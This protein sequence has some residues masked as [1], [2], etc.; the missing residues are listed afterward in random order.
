MFSKNRENIKPI[1]EE[2]EDSKFTLFDFN[3]SAVSDIK[4]SAFITE[5]Q[6][7]K[8]F[9]VDPVSMNLNENSAGKEKLLK[10]DNIRNNLE[11]IDEIS[12]CNDPNTSNMDL[13]IN[14]KVYIK[15]F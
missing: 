12:H 10:S 6:F 2:N 4:T 5:R 3:N 15:F 14:E 1:L 7:G 13:A 8:I 11:I 9:N